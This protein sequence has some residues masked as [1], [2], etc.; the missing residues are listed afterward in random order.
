MPS[1]GSAPATPRP[2]LHAEAVVTTAVSIAD[3]QGLGAVSMRAVATRLGVEAMSLYHHVPN[4]ERL[5]DA[6]VDVVFTEFYVPVAGQ[7]WRAEIRRRCVSG[8]AALRRH[9]WAVGL[10]DSRRSP[11]PATLVAHDALLGCLRTDGFSL[12]LAAHAFALVDAHLYGFLVQEVS[13][14]ATTGAEL[15]DLAV[16]MLTPEVSAAM[17]HLAEIATQ[18]TL[19]PGYDFGDEFDWGLDLI[20][21]G[22][23]AHHAH[24]QRSAEP[25]PGS[26]PLVTE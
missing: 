21:D 14:P 8:R 23:A 4:K 2:A 19:L 5:L 22:L 16:T 24:D 26:G 7:P 20:L 25:I 9:P 15:H 6:M 1:R 18:H 10:M 12:P 11:G 3:A 17:P 13:L